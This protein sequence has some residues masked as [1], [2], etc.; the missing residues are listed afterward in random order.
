MVPLLITGGFTESPA[1]IS[2]TRTAYFFSEVITRWTFENGFTAY[3]DMM[4]RGCARSD[5]LVLPS[6]QDA[7]E[8]SNTGPLNQLSPA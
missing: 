2:A 8:G 5:I 7:F 1:K 3:K 4:I 6:L